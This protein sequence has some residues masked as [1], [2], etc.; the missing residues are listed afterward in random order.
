VKVYEDNLESMLNGSSAYQGEYAQLGQEL[1]GYVG[2]TYRARFAAELAA[3]EAEWNEQRRDLQ[4]KQ[5]AWRE[6]AGLILERGRSDWKAGI[7]RLRDS[8]TSWKK[9]FA[10]SYA[11]GSAAWD[12]AYLEGLKEKE[13]WAERA[14]AAAT[15]AASDAMLALVGQDAEAGARTFETLGL[16]ADL[17]SGAEE[18]KAGIREVLSMAGIVNLTSAL[19]ASMGSAETTVRQVRTG[20]GGLGLWDSG[21]AQVAAARFTK[22]ANQ[23]LASRQARLVAAQAREMAQASIKGLEEQVQKANENFRESMDETFV[24]KGSWRKEGQNYTKDVVV[25]STLLDPVVTEG[26]SVQGYIAYLMQPVSLRTDL[27]DT[28]LA[29]L[30][31]SAIQALIGQAQKEVQEASEKIF[32]SEADN[33]EEA[34]AKRKVVY[35]VDKTKTVATDLWTMLTTFKTTKDV[36][37]ATNTEEREVGAGEFGAHLGYAPVTKGNPNVDDGLDNIWVDPGKGELG[38][39]MRSYIYWSMKESQGWASVNKPMWDKPAWDDRSSWFKAPTIRG[40]TDIG[41]TI[42]ATIITA[43]AGGIGGALASAAVNLADDAV[44]TML[45]VGGGYKS[46]EEAGLEFGKKAACSAVNIGVGQL[47]S[48]A[49]AMANSTQGIGG[50]IGST[51]LSGMQTVTTSTLNSAVNAITWDK[52]HGLGWSSD[53]FNA[54]VQGGLISAATG[55]TS[56]F[57]SGVL[58]NWN[59]GDK[60][61]GFSQLNQKDVYTLNSTIGNLA[62]QGVNFALTG[63]FTVNVLNMGDFTN[64]AIKTGLLELHLGKKGATMNVGMGGADVSFGTVASAMRGVGVVSVNQEIS[65][66]VKSK[67]LDIAVTLRSQYGFGDGV[68]QEQL[69][70]LLRDRASI[71]IGG[72]DSANA[73]AQ[74]KREG[75]QRVIHIK[76]YRAGMSKEEQLELGIT[77]A[78][79]AYRNGIDDGIAGQRIETNQ[80]VLGHIGF[81]ANMAG[82]YGVG[83]IGKDMSLEVVAY[84]KALQGDTKALSEVLSSYDA[85]GDYWKLTA[86]GGLEYDGEGYLRGVNGEYIRD[87]DGNKIGADGIEGGLI[88]IMQKAGVN[89][90]SEQAAQ[91]LAE[92]GFQHSNPDSEDTST[93]M[94]NITGEDGQQVNMGAVLSAAA[95]GE[96]STY[97]TI[98]TALQTG[99]N[100]R[101][102][103]WQTSW[104]GATD[105]QRAYFNRYSENSYQELF[106]YYNANDEVWAEGSPIAWF[107]NNTSEVTIG[108]RTFATHND[109]IPKFEQL[110]QI[111]TDEQFTDLMAGSVGSLNARFVRG[112]TEYLSDH[113]F[114]QAIDF[115]PD[116]NPFIINGNTL[117]ETA[118]F[119]LMAA[120]ANGTAASLQDFDTFMAANSRLQAIN[121]MGG[122]DTFLDAYSENRQTLNTLEQL[123]NAGGPV[124]N[125]LI[126]A[127]NSAQQYNTDYAGLNT[128]LTETNNPLYAQWIDDGVVNLD[129]TYINALRQSGFDWGALFRNRIDGMHFYY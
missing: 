128:L 20:L 40:V 88:A 43:P 37:E 18:A 12:G 85:S 113:A 19:N 96:D 107:V 56:S 13:A 122:I 54:G 94:W 95:F 58:N 91:M 62:G 1:A 125:W 46:W 119:N 7:E 99:L 89:L 111:L 69:R 90:N 108:G 75:A 57:T 70:D 16:V 47:F 76:G 65:S 15:T 68:Q 41:V 81:A 102:V 53:A 32:G 74:T 121:N 28:K 66:Y 71:A 126:N 60:L 26:A 116:S 87:K 114:G 55:M 93:W 29:Q 21:K 100:N 67:Q 59:A 31:Y 77:L 127:I 83:S 112:S 129:P 8:Y 10:E 27:S 64:G 80:A 109:S 36:V 38:R 84:M 2:Q 9:S 30:E 3:R 23:E 79:E 78:H 52:E 48:P 82:T 124:D 51:M 35:K 117:R 97:G 98:A 5:A 72:A 42:A 115:Y 11:Q 103:D 4:E 45:D 14:T 63:D 123:I 24:L 49:I 61:F 39:L 104:N 34:K 110:A 118:A 92:A 33:S 6:A 106:A 86:D 17:S 25:Y 105:A 73:D 120:A 22:E 44:F 101:F 50:V